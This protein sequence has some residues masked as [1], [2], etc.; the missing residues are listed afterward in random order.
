MVDAAK[1]DESAVSKVENEKK[2]A[3]TTDK[4]EEVAPV[5][6]EDGELLSPHRM[7]VTTFA[8]QDQIFS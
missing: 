8:S 1:K 6:V 7:R 5:K 4:V 3:D 2:A